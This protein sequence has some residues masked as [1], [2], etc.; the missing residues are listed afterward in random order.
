MNRIVS[1]SNNTVSYLSHSILAHQSVTT[2]TQ[3]TEF[4]LVQEN[5]STVREIETKITDLFA[6]VI[7]ASV[8]ISIVLIGQFV[9]GRRAEAFNNNTGVFESGF[10]LFQVRLK[11]LGPR[12]RVK[13]A[14]KATY[15]RISS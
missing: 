10:R 9:H 1:H 4:G 15:A 3:E 12:C 2:P 5:L 11:D 6:V 7:V 13:V 14:E 8:R